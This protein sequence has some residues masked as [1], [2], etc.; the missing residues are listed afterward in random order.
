[1]VPESERLSGVSS[2]N[3]DLCHDH[4]VARRI[5]RL[6]TANLFSFLIFAI[7]NL[8]IAAR[9]VLCIENKGMSIVFLK[10]DLFQKTLFPVSII[11]V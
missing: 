7:R 10:N 3:G 8:P 11:L 6:F 2:R 9:S 5:V 4:S 1:M